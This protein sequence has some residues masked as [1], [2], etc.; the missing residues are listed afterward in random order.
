LGAGPS[1][2]T[3]NSLPGDTY[4]GGFVVYTC[5]M[6]KA[7]LLVLPAILERF[8]TYLAFGISFLGFAGYIL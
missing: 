4:L 8:D 1:G 6:N 2:L 5:T 7:S 3:P